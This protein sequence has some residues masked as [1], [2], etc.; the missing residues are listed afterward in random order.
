MKVK[1]IVQVECGDA[2]HNLILAFE[3]VSNSSDEVL[4]VSEINTTESGSV[5]IIFTHKEPNE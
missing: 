5:E 2:D 1:H 4:Y 3:G